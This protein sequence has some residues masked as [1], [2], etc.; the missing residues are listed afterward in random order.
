MLIN[1]NTFENYCKILSNNLRGVINMSDKLNIS[2]IVTI[3]QCDHRQFAD[4]IYGEKNLKHWIDKTNAFFK[5]Q[6]QTEDLFIEIFINDNVEN[7][8]NNLRKALKEFFEFYGYFKALYEKDEFAI[9]TWE[10]TKVIEKNDYNGL[11][12]MLKGG[13]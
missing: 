12:K 1:D 6:M 8:F 7:C 4:L 5:N 3:A 10:I 13:I 2:N 11:L 9:A